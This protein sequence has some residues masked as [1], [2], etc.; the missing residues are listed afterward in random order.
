MKCFYHQDRD[1]VGLC[2]S[3]GRGLCLGCA[4]DLTEALACQGKCERSV[5]RLLAVRKSS[6]ETVRPGLGARLVVPA[7][8]M[9]T[10]LLFVAVSQLILSLKLVLLPLGALALLG[11]V[12][13]FVVPWRQA[14]RLR[15]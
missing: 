13:A 15:A 7:F 12:A 8:L 11:G 4:A 2:Q 10:G 5:H 14:R 6:L 3:C 9:L 1:A